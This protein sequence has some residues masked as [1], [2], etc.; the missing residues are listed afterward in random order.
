MLPLLNS[1]PVSSIAKEKILINDFKKVPTLLLPIFSG[2]MLLIG[3]LSAA[4]ASEYTFVVQP[5]EQPSQ[6]IQQYK[7]LADY[8]R[9]QTGLNIKLVTERNFLTYWVNIKNGKYDLILDA[10]H[11]TDYRVKNL[12]YS[13]LAKIPDTVTYSL[14]THKDNLVLDLAELIGKK[15]VTLPPPSMGA[16]QLLQLFDN[17]SRQPR[18][19]STKSALHAIQS[20]LTKK[21]FAALVPTPL[22][23]DVNDINVVTS[24]TPLPHMAFSAS[25]RLS[26]NQHKLIQ[27]AL[28]NAKINEK[29]KLVLK[30]LQIAEF[31]S[32]NEKTYQGYEKYLAVNKRGRQQR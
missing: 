16:T 4:N 15:L 21:A 17:P 12:S 27:D 30:H 32:T 18:I 19:I 1:M 3:M 23:H 8:L 28:L 5:V 24:T 14:I 10:A 2:F 6:S 11:F 13:I 29:G 31:K 9:E 7:P 22:L 20:V 25:K 26:K